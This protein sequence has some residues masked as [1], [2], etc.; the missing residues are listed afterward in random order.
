MAIFMTSVNGVAI[1]RLLEDPQLF[2][3]STFYKA[4]DNRYV[5]LLNTYPHLRDINCRVLG[6]PCN[7]TAFAT[8]IAEWDA[9]DLEEVVG[10]QGGTCIAVRTREEWLQTAAGAILRETSVI[11]IERIGDTAPEPLAELSD[12]T[13]GKPLDGVRVLDNT[14][15]IAGPMAARICGEY[16]A[17]VLLMSS[18]D[19][20]DPRTMTI[21]TAIGKRSAFCDLRSEEDRE[22]F[23]KTLKDADVYVSSYLSLDKK[24]FGPNELIKARPGLIYCDFH[25]WGK[26]GP[27]QQWGGF[28][29]L[30]CSATGF[31]HTEGKLREDGRPALPPTY[32]LNDYLAAILGTA[33]MTE[34]LRRRAIEGGSYRVHVNLSR[35]AMWVQSLGTFE[36]TEV[37]KIPKPCS[38]GPDNKPAADSFHQDVEF[39]EVDGPQGSTRYLP[40]QI[41]YANGTIKPDLAVGSEPTGAS[42]FAFLG[43]GKG[44][45]QP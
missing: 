29:Q 39:K 19:Y 42:R 10:Q 44:I 41:T 15:V 33:G 20:P 27:W 35:V 17:E 9:F 24:G 4:K 32:L 3:T 45:I 22:K 30:A 12:H 1:R 2:A 43:G 36:I 38:L 31:A 18:P 28:D 5:F 25:G 26:S 23:W 7:V 8:T 34:A 16:G 11:D 13:A 40:T 14:H 21:E 6:S 37:S